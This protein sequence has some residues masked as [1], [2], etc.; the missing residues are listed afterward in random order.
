MKGVFQGLKLG[1][2]SLLLTQQMPSLGTRQRSQ[3]WQK[4]S[5]KGLRS[6][7]FLLT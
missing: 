7:S 5:W 3:T 1:V 2:H 6:L 4:L